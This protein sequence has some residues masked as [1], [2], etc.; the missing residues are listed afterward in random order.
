MRP[1]FRTA[2]ELRTA[3]KAFLEST[4]LNLKFTEQDLIKI[5]DSLPPECGSSQP[6]N[7]RHQR[8]SVLIM[9]EPVHSLPPSVSF[10]DTLT[11]SDR[12]QDVKLSLE[13][14]ETRYSH[15]NQPFSARWSIT[16]VWARIR[17]SIPVA[18]RVAY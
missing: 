9:P 8:R 10:W 6:G 13:G 17:G 11:I 14:G 15:L 7:P 1:E 3:E 12:R 4:Q 5:Y 18:F 2:D 16:K